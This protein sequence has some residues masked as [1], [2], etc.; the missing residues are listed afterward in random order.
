MKNRIYFKHHDA[1]KSL[2]RSLGTYE[3]DDFLQSELSNFTKDVVSAR[4]RIYRIK[5]SMN[6]QNNSDEK[7]HL[8]YELDEAI[9]SLS[10]FLDKLK[11]ADEMY[12]CYKEYLKKHYA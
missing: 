1:I 3:T 2:I 5:E 7:K 10:A 11:I 4:E 8:Q 6:F 12:I 9:N